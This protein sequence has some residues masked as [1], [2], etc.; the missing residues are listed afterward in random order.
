MIHTYLMYVQKKRMVNKM[1][2]KEFVKA[3]KAICEEKKIDY[4][5]LEGSEEIGGQLTRL[6]PEKD[7][8]D[9]PG[10]ECIKSKDYIEHLRSKVSPDCIITNAQVT[11]IKNGDKIQLFAGKTA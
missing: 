2:E 4:L 5:V 7:I 6:Y 10:I 8:V 3:L 1:N 9:I 11:D